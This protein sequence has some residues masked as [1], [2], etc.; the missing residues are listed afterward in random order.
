MIHRIETTPAMY[1]PSDSQA[2]SPSLLND[3]YQTVVALI[4]LIIAGLGL[5]IVA[6]L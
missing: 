4:P 5:R 2:D 1:D 3:R 6:V